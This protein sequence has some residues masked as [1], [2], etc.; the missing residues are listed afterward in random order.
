MSLRST[1]CKEAC[2][3][4]A[5][6]SVALADQFEPF[7]EYFMPILIKLTGNSVNIIAEAG[8]QCIA[9]ILRSSKVDKVIP[10]ICQM[11]SSNHN[12]MRLRSMEYIFQLMVDSPH[13][14]VSLLDKYADQ[15]SN[16]IQQG[17]TDA[18]P[19]VRST[20]RQCFPHFKSRW[21][22][23]ANRIFNSIPANAQKYLCEEI[24]EE[25]HPRG[26]L[27]KTTSWKKPQKK[28]TKTP[29]TGSVVPARIAISSNSQNS[30]NSNTF[31]H[32]YP[33]S[34]SLPNSLS[35]GMRP[36]R[37][38]EKFVAAESNTQSK[39]YL[40]NS[41]PI[42]VDLME[43]P[44]S[45]T[46]NARKDN[47]KLKTP[48]RGNLYRVE[49]IKSLTVY[50]L[51]GSNKG[52]GIIQRVF[53]E[54]SN[55]SSGSNNKPNASKESQQIQKID[56]QPSII[57]DTN[58]EDDDDGSFDISTIL[59][60]ASSNLWSVRLE[61]FKQLK[62]AL[63]VSRPQMMHHFSKIIRLITKHLTDTHHKVL[64]QVLEA[65][66]VLV[67]NYSQPLA[68]HLE[69]ILPL[70]VKLLSDGKERLLNTNQLL[71][72]SILKTFE[73]DLLMPIFLRALEL[74]HLKV[75]LCCLEYVHRLLPQT[76]QFFQNK[77]RIPHQ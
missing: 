13:S 48:S 2:H 62:N 14:T 1:L 16:C 25:I 73:G 6:L 49:M 55:H 41:A 34:F 76:T 54:A 30:T 31:N 33:I 59:D 37:L 39:K 12:T 46:A 29:S 63:Q 9:T 69:T 43:E 74:P 58:F 36:E 57:L 38:E 18:I 35:N 47:G 3:T 67:S 4:V 70:L 20:S 19:S 64:L 66:V 24:T 71:L 23:R 65:V 17:L 28:D 68:P 77:S 60:N 51:A 53:A 50:T 7:T 42:R 22:E 32:T 11:T 45:K 61:C 5:E 10:Q 56:M 15:L 27:S 75:K 21:P 44:S 52:M 72:E 40:S 26:Q 8:N